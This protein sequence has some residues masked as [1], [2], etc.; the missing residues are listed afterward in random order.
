MNGVRRAVTGSTLVG[1]LA[2]S[3]WVGGAELALRVDPFARPAAAPVAPPADT[4]AAAA[5]VLPPWRGRLMMTLRAGA[6]SLVNVDGEVVT[7][8]AHYRGFELVAVGE[9]T[10]RFQ[11]GGESVEVSLDDPAVPLD[12]ADTDVSDHASPY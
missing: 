9:R 6:R 10:A 12:L 11:R 2:T 3:A 4:L 8:G 1:A 7:L 5:A